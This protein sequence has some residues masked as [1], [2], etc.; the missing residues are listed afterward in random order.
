[1]FESYRHNKKNKFQ[2]FKV[3]DKRFDSDLHAYQYFTKN[4]N[5]EIT[6]NLDLRVMDQDWQKEPE[7]HLSYY[8]R[9]MCEHIKQHYDKIVLDTVVVP[10]VRPYWSPFL[11]PRQ[12]ILN[13]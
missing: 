12:K 11:R 4:L 6:F 5:N 1:M 7:Q 8:K 10:T 2:Y 3:G 13:C 9:A